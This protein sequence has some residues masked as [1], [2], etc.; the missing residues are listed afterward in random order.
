MELHKG[1]P[2]RRLPSQ[3]SPTVGRAAKTH[4]NTAEAGLNRP[5]R[6]A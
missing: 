2:I 3:D 4:E 6:M 1:T 5:V